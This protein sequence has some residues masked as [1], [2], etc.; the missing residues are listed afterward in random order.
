[1]GSYRK[2]SSVRT[3]PQ[4]LSRGGNRLIERSVGALLTAALL[5]AM[6]VAFPGVSSASPTSA[7]ATE[8]YVA[9]ASPAEIETIDS[10]T[11]AE[12]G[13]ATSLGSSTP[14]AMAEYRPTGSADPQL[15][16]GESGHQLAEVDPLSQTENAISLA[17][18]PTAVAVA[19]LSTTSAY[20]LVLEP[21]GDRVQVIDAKTFESKGSVSLGLGTTASGLA[22]NPDGEYAY[23]TDST[24]HEAVTL[25]GVVGYQNCRSSSCGWG[26][27]GGGRVDNSRLCGRCRLIDFAWLSRRSAGGCSQLRKRPSRRWRPVAT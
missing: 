13:S 9:I 16:V 20:A 7:Q 2:H 10:T 14:I 8:T 24:T 11:G 27:R 25:Y 4:H 6:L 21:A 1:M 17:Y 26:V 5:A 22:F 18:A 19:N 23:V 3:R 12:V 15:L